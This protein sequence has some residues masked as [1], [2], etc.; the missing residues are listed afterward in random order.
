MKGTW[1]GKKK[2]LDSG[3]FFTKALFN[4]S[5]GGGIIGKGPLLAEKGKELL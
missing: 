1:G 2:A 3:K 4:F 5:L